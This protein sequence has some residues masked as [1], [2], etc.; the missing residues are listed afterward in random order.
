MDIL[1]KN[2]PDGICGND[3]TGQMSAWFVWSAMGFYPVRHGTGEYMVG[4]PLF[5]HLE[6]AH[7]KGKLVILAPTVSS[8][9]KYIKGIRLNGKELKRFYLLHH[10]LFSGNALLEFEMTDTPIIE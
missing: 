6:L 4:T 9:N 3:D 8:I 1:Y 7:A 5:S 10:E 2:S